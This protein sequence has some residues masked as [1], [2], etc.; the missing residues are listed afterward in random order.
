MKLK[1][2][3]ILCGLAAAGCAA[4]SREIQPAGERNIPE[5][6]VRVVMPVQAGQME[7][8]TRAADEDTVSDLNVYLFDAYSR[9]LTLHSY[10]TSMELEF[11][12]VPGNYELYVI[13]NAYADLG[14]LQYA[15]VTDRTVNF[16]VGLRSLPMSAMRE[17]QI[18]Q[19]PGNRVT[20]PPLELERDMA[21]ITYSISAA[22]AM[23]GMEIVSLQVCNIPRRGA[24]FGDTAP[25]AQEDEY[26]ASNRSIVMDGQ[27]RYTD[28]LYMPQN[29]Q[30]IVASVT[31]QRLKDA[32][33]A[34]QYAT[35]L[36]IRAV[37]ENKVLE[38]R[39]YLGE[40]NTTDF[41]VRR[42]T[43]YS[44]DITIE[45]ESEVDTRVQCY[46]LDVYD[47]LENSD[48]A[49][50]GYCIPSKAW[51]LH[52]D[53]A[54]NTAGRKISGTVT[55]REGVASCFK[56][57]TNPY[58]QTGTIALWNQ[59]GPNALPVIYNPP[60]VTEANGWIEYDVLLVDDGGF[61]KTYT[62][63]HMLANEIR[64]VP[65]GDEALTVTGAPYYLRQE[66]G[67]LRI[68]CYENGCT[69]RAPQYSAGMRFAGWYADAAYRTRLSTEVQYL[70]KPSATLTLLY[71]KYE[72][73]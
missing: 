10:L 38:Y 58:G 28:E 43:R 34:P 14:E 62:F 24:I 23:K 33:Y 8:V 41:N 48:A 7:C 26:V 52:F 19:Q 42:N 18:E 56:F 68:A 1:S 66:D 65:Y 67:T 47:D 55:L 37:R 5:G 4:C 2:M 61:R 31:D 11:N 45:G 20:L 70:C 6:Q 60:V 29:C 50:S 3:I 46:T 36:M 22:P 59:N 25:S 54:G 21:K 53:I 40:N 64:A 16:M 30:G 17:L 49:L 71:A 73:I 35:Y 51:N 44:L 9:E 72:K 32:D 63:R 27:G 12:C 15:Q 13:A 69:L 39:V 57:N